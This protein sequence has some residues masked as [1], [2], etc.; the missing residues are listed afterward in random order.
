MNRAT[1]A[2][3][4]GPLLAVAAVQLLIIAVVPS[5]AQKNTDVETE[6]SAQSGGTLPPGVGVIDPETGQIVDPNTGQVLDPRTG[7]PVGASATGSG[8]GGT[9]GGGTG[10][11]GGGGTV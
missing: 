11:G 5:T 3:R 6:E 8:D 10:G 9:G 7:S 2:R 1:L 4:Y